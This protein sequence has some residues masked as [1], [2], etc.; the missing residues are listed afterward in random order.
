MKKLLSLFGLV[1]LM[2][3]VLAGCGE[4][5]E[6]DD[7]SVLNGLFGQF[8]DSTEETVDEEVVEEEMPNSEEP[9]APPSAYINEEATE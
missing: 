8:D 7:E 6:S 1:A 9:E 2:T 4:V 3:A 5:E